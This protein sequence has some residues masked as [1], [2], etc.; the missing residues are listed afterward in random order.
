M[1]QGLTLDSGALIA[2]ERGNEKVREMLRRAARHHRPVHV[3]PGVLA[4]VWRGGPRQAELARFLERDE[5][6]LLSLDPD[7][8]RA[9]GVLVGR[10]G[11]TDVVDVHVALH[12]RLH[13]HAVMTSDPHDLRSVDLSLT[14]VEL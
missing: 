4:Q 5:V 3:V 10:T 8:A 9:I 1:D 13:G 2:L 11:H 14:L 7:T 12:A 6:E